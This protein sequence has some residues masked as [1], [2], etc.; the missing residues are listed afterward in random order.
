LSRFF[1]INN[2][3]ERKIFGYRI[4]ADQDGPRREAGVE[5]VQA[6]S[7]GGRMRGSPGFA[8]VPHPLPAGLEEDR[9]SVQGRDLPVLS[10]AVLNL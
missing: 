6:R 1:P 3:N 9:V 8:N 5:I 2:I 7:E 10:A 4:A